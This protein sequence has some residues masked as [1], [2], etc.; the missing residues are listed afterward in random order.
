MRAFSPPPP[1]SQF[2]LYYL[3]R[4][5]VTPSTRLI[6]LSTC[7]LGIALP[8]SYSCT[9][10]GFSLICCASCACVSFLAVRAAMICFLRSEETFSWWKSSV[11]FSS[12]AADLPCAAPLAL[13]PA[14]TVVVGFLMGLGSVRFYEGVGALFRV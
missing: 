10:C 14:A 12:L 9:S 3:P 4:L 1:K 8:L 11:S 7:G 13:V 2:L 5:S 6:L